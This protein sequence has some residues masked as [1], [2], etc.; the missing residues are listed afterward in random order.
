M[1]VHWNGLIAVLEIDM[2]TWSVFV[3]RKLPPRRL[4]WVRRWTRYNTPLVKDW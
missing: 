3:W 2:G 4:V 1:N